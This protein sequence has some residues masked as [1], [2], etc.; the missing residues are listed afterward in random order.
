MFITSTTVAAA[1]EYAYLIN[2]IAF[3]QNCIFTMC[4]KYTLTITKPCLN[5]KSDHS[6]SSAFFIGQ[7]MRQEKKYNPFLPGEN[8]Y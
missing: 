6:A 3:L 1:A 7:R 8:D 4:C 2:K 5:E